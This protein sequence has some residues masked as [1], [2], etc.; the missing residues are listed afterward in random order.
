MDIPKNL[1]DGSSLWMD[2]EFMNYL[3]NGKPEIGWVGDPRLAPYF[4]QDRIELRR[5]D[6]HGNFRHV[7]A[8][9]RPG[10]RHLGMETLVFLAEHDSESRRKYDVVQDINSHNDKVRAGRDARNADRRG[11]AIDRLAHALRK[12]V[13]AY[14]GGTTRQFFP[15]IDISSKGQSK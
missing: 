13:G 3:H 11:E 5:A 12:D 9:S 4:Y 2:S 7:V 8:R 10:M 15:G 1:P 14:E 6:E